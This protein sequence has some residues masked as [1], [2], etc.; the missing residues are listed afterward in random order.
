MPYKYYFMAENN[1]E[2]GFITEKLWEPIICE[3]L[4]FNQGAPDVAKSM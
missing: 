3:C 2:P 4:V 1:F